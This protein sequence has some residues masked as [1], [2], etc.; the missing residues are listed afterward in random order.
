[1]VNLFIT[2]VVMDVDHLKD[3]VYLLGLINRA[4]YS[5]LMENV[6]SSRLLPKCIRD[7]MSIDENTRSVKICRH[8]LCNIDSDCSKVPD[9]FE[10]IYEE[11]SKL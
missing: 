5:I 9:G 10:K 8:S 6:T 11:L 7:K 2:V 1:M 3:K 4:E